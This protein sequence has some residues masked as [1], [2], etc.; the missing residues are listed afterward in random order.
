MK[1]VE[2][3]WYLLNCVIMMSFTG[4]HETSHDR[5]HVSEIPQL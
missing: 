4:G 5:D 2:K 1:W 3:I